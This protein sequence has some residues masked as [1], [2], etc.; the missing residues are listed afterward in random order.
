MRSACLW[1]VRVDHN[2]DAIPMAVKTIAIA[3][4]QVPVMTAP[5]K[6]TTAAARTS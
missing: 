6:I 5:T 3:V 2:D 1:P 4:S